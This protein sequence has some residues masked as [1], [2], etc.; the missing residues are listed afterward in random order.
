MLMVS[1]CLSN[2]LNANF[3][4]G[5]NCNRALYKEEL[6]DDITDKA[7]MIHKRSNKQ[8]FGMYKAFTCMKHDHVWPKN[9]HKM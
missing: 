6:D 7:S 2:A 4:T 5:A 8:R 3:A 1:G 9:R